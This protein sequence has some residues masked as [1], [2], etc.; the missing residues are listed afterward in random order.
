MMCEHLQREGRAYI[1]VMGT[2]EVSLKAVTQNRR[3]VASSSRQWTERSK[4]AQRRAGPAVASMQLPQISQWASV[5][6]LQ[7][8]S[9]HFS[10]TGCGE[11]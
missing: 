5:S 4:A 1:G 6:H 3:L 8:G 7:G 9:N 11:C 10:A 2:R